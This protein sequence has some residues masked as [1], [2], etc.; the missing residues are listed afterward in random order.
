VLE[1]TLM[2]QDRFVRL[3][4]TNSG[5][6][7][8]VLGR[9]IYSAWTRCSERS[10]HLTDFGS[11][12]GVMSRGTSRSA[13]GALASRRG[14]VAWVV[15]VVIVLVGSG[16]EF[17]RLKGSANVIY[18]VTGDG[19]AATIIYSTLSGAEQQSTVALPWRTSVEAPPTDSVT[20]TAGYGSGSIACVISSSN[21]KILA[22]QTKSGQSAVVT[23]KH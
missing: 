4:R 16:Y 1:S 5:V 14:V 20:A 10:S 8:R 21:G 6:N 17:A 11:T 7:V 12:I 3:P 9:L 19:V 13:L 22:T 15:V 2:N 23:C 18:S